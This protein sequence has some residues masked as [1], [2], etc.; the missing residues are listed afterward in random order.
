MRESKAIE[1][2]SLIQRLLDRRAATMH[3]YTSVMYIN[4]KTFLCLL[5]NLFHVSISLIFSFI[6]DE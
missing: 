4:K 1:N 6:D 5:Y 3:I 2:F